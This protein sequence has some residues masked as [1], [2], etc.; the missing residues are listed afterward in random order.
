MTAVIFILGLQEPTRNSQ[1]WFGHLYLGLT[2]AGKK[3]PKNDHGHFDL[4]PRRANQTKNKND[5]VT[6]ILGLPEQA[7]NS[8]QI[9]AVFF[10]LGL[11]EPAWNSQQL[12][13]HL[14]LWLTRAGQKQ[15]SVCIYGE[16]KTW[17]NFT[18]SRHCCCTFVNNGQLPRHPP[19]KYSLTGS[20]GDLRRPH[21]NH[22]RP[23]GLYKKNR[24]NLFSACVISFF[25][26]RARRGFYFFGVI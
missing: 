18:M 16:V 26:S 20:L 14:H 1:K 13:S 15:A 22:V 7:R 12:F 11:Q 10:I 8:Q 6:C 25:K 4:G 24:F 19:L 23:C 17:K 9:A 5:S 2:R 3:Q 21:G